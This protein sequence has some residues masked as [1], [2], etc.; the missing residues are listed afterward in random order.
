[1][2]TTTTCVAIF[3]SL[4]AMAAAAQSSN[5]R[6]FDASALFQ[7]GMSTMQRTRETCAKGPG[8]EFSA[9]FVQHMQAAGASPPRRWLSCTQSTTTAS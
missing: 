1:M 9:C 3:V 2:K 8:R 4:A 6:K 7:P 5:T